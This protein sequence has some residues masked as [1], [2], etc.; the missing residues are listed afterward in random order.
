LQ[1]HQQATATSVVIT[2]CKLQPEIFA[3][4]Q[5]EEPNVFLQT[6]NTAFDLPFQKA[7]HNIAQKIFFFKYGSIFSFV[8]KL[9]N[10]QLYT[11]LRYRQNHGRQARL[12]S[13]EMPPYP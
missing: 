11:I 6:P 9:K 12:R 8:A 7:S 5:G 3:C 13:A 10:R 1:F 2:L 4:R